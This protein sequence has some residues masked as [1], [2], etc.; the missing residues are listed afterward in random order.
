MEIATIKCITKPW[1]E[2]V[3]LAGKTISQVKR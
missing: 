1:R 3:Y 2:I